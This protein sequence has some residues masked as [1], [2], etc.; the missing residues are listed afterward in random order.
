ML[1]TIEMERILKI[2]E[3]TNDA[4]VLREIYSWLSENELLSYVPKNLRWKMI[5]ALEPEELPPEEER[6][7]VQKLQHA[8]KAD[9]IS[10]DEVIKRL[11]LDD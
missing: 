7:L 1:A 8:E 4:F 9:V 11:G 5:D 3:N 10:L 6:E 2:I